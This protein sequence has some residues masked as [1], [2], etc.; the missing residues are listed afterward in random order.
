MKKNKGFTLIELL[1]VIAIIGI[2]ASVVLAS[3][4]SARTKAKVAVVQ[5][6]LASM[7]PQAELGVVNGKYLANICTVST[8]GGLLLLA[9]SINPA[10]TPGA[11]TSN[12]KCGQNAP[13]DTVSNGWGAEVTIDGKIFC[14]DSTGFTGIVPLT[15]ITAGVGSADVKC[16]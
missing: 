7:R 13:A 16:L 3:L 2:L 10:V 5:S 6:T 15:T 4:S 9:N 14:A 1:V 11:K 12:F 8:P